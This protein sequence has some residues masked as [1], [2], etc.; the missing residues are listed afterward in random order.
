MIELKPPCPYCGARYVG[1]YGW[2]HIC[3][4]TTYSSMPV[5][6]FIP[7]DVGTPEPPPEVKRQGAAN[8]IHETLF[9]EELRHAGHTRITQR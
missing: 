7:F 1:Q 3:K 9:G 8:V 2:P 4:E 5:L 6:N